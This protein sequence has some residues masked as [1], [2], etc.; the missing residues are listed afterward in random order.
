MSLTLRR[1]LLVGIG[2]SIVGLGVIYLAKWLLGLGDISANVL[3]Y[4]IGLIV[5]YSLNRCWT[6]RHEGGFVTSIAAFLAVQAVAFSL[7]LVCVLQLIG[8]GA[9]SYVAQ[10]LGVPP[11]ALISYLGSKYFAFASG[12]IERDQLDLKN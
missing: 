7:N 6:F 11:Y 2:N 3:G 9:D 1:F 10:A 4:G 12:R 5:G 8:L